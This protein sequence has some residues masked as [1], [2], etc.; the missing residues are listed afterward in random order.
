MRLLWAICSPEVGIAWV[1]LSWFAVLSCSVKELAL[2][3][4]LTWYQVLIV[5]LLHRSIGQNCCISF[6]S[7]QNVGFPETYKCQ[8]FPCKPH[9][10]I[11]HLVCSVHLCKKTNVAIAVLMWSPTKVINH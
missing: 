4:P 5:S 7:S 2:L 8:W 10:Q 6:T 3:K 11:P 9:S 1:S